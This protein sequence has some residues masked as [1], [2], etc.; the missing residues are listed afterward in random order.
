MLK[1]IKIKPLIRDLISVDKDN[2]IN[3]FDKNNS[4]ISKTKFIIKKLAKFK[5]LVKSKDLN[6]R[7]R[8]FTLK[9]KLIFAKLRQIFIKTLIF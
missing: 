3:R 2:I 7:L 4:K 6:S 5:V 9:T 8:F 1:I